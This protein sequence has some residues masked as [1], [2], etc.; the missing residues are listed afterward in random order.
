MHIQMRYNMNGVHLGDLTDGL[1][2]TKSK[3]TMYKNTLLANSE[4]PLEELMAG[5]WLELDQSEFDDLTREYF[6]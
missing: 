6:L 5:E 4:V 2:I 3:R 1:F